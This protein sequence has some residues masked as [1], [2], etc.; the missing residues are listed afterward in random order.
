[1]KY[2][3]IICSFLAF[4]CTNAGTKKK[5]AEVNPAIQTNMSTVAVEL[6]IQGMTCLGCEQT[7][8]SGIS[9]IKGVKQVKANFRSGK[10]FVEFIPAMADTIRMKEKITASGYVVAGIKLIP[11]D[12]LRSKL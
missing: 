3:I 9:S 8:Q 2:L 6:S 7:I 10:A 5:Q 1:M 4:G 11:L 12:T